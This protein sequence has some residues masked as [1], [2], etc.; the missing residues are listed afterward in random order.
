MDFE[1]YNYNSD[2]ND[3]EYN[4]EIKR[5]V[6]DT[7]AIIEGNIEKIIKEKGLNYPEVIIPEA[8]ISELEHQ[9]NNQRPTGLRGLENL[10]KL[11]EL[12]E[13][14]GLAIRV[15]GRRPTKF[16]KDNAKL[17][18]IDGLIRDVAKDELAVLIT[19]DKIQAK[20]AEAQGIPVIYYAQEYKGN[21]DLKIAKFFDN[22]TM[23]VHL[24]ENVVPMAKK[25]K[26]GD[27]KLVK[28]ANEKFTYKQLENI[29]EEILEKER[30][31]SKTYL[32]V[33]REGAIVV[34]SR[35]LRISIAR[36][37]FSESLEITAVR[38][39]AEVSLDEY[40]L[41]AKLIER[42][43]NS[44]RGILISGSPGAGKSTFAQAIA[45]FY[46]E[47]LNKVVKT[48][49]SPRDL[50]VS[51]TITQYAPLEGDM[52]NTADILL[53]VRPD[54]TIYDELRKNHDFKIFADMRLAGV[55]MIG[56]VHATRPIDA[57]QRIAN[58]VD[59]G[60]IPS[61]VDTTIYI[62][63]GEIS[64]IYENKL[65]V[66][67]PTGM[68]ERDLARPVIE[69]RDFETGTLVNEIYTYG[70]Q[71]I[72]MD[73][74]MVENSKRE[75][76]KKDKSPV[77]LI[78]E[79]EILRT[80]KRI[81]PKAAIEISLE[82]DKRVNIYMSEKHIPKIIGKG[83]KRIAELE[84]DI[85]ISINV[86]PLEKAADSFESRLAKRSLKKRKKDKKAKKSQLKEHNDAL[87][88]Y[89]LSKKS[90]NYSKDNY[91]D[92][93]EGEEYI[94]EDNTGEILDE[95][96]ANGIYYEVFELYP[97]VRKDH[98]VLPIGK[99]YAGNSF[100]IL[101]EDKYLFTATVG[102]RGYVK[103]NKNLDLTDEIIDGLNKSLRLIARVID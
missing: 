52:E 19:S 87:K 70:E 18:E 40:H 77:Q 54:F 63:N 100:D 39:V 50:Q 28:L 75:K 90:R 41:S 92:L 56:V 51:D 30:Y 85:G 29:A 91:F 13:V 9:A 89:K 86:K 79:R 93:E 96:N 64:T 60:T 10:K 21:L 32:E 48:M 27:I 33:D 103:L 7:S 8:V 94:D 95:D 25:G 11:Q 42:L 26:P 83:G 81:A 36:P 14:G 53:L 67:V 82:N 2:Y 99:A 44:A 72:V 1:E 43:T 22:E 58:R 5:I 78:A 76:T 68:E 84:N 66:K 65:T 20:T 102:K 47:N 97:E 55:G 101:L 17:G 69:V 24:K 12:S 16:E 49:E 45:K 38:P 61:I 35:D 98:L 23:S 31:D 37:P 4:D 71:T 88:D 62:E 74:G 57:I 3:D 59:L 15:T 34:Q 73:I 80:M 46:D 6:P